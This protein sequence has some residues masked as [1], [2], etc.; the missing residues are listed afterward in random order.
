MTK[1]TKC[2]YIALIALSLLQLVKLFNPTPFLNQFHLSSSNFA[3]WS[4][5]QLIPSMY[6]YSNS[7]WSSYDDY[8]QNTVDEIASEELDYAGEQVNHFPARVLTFRLDREKLFN[9]KVKSVYIRSCFAGKVL[10][11]AYE[12]EIRD[13]VAHLELRGT[14]VVL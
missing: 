12:V 4:T 5:I 13:N 14:H 11:S 7:V 6:N 9:S 1:S 8:S 3:Q 2:F 10:I